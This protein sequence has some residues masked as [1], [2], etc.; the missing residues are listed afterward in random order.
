M[1]FKFAV[2]FSLV[3]LLF[4]GMTWASADD[5]ALEG[6]QGISWGTSLKEFKS[7]QKSFAA[8]SVERTQARA[9]D[10]LMMNFHEVDK[11]DSSRPTK[12]VDEK[13]NRDQA[14]H[15][16]YDG[17]YSLAATPIAYENV[18]VNG[19]RKVQRLAVQKCNTPRLPYAFRGCMVVG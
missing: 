12:F 11:N 7:S 1:K 13:I 15:I 6:Y 18:G 10:Y 14:D 8:N 19:G 16:F 4:S 5:N 2:I 9:I 17:R 3:V